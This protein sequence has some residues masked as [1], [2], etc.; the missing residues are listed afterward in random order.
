MNITN[1]MSAKWIVLLFTALVAGCGGGGGDEGG[2]G[3]N[4]ILGINDDTNNDTTSQPSVSVRDLKIDRDNTLS[5]VYEVDVDVDISAQS[6]ARAFISIC[7]NSDAKGDLKAI[8]YDNCMIK[9]RLDQGIGQYDLRIANHCTELIAVIWVMEKD[10]DPMTYT[11]THDKS[12]Q[13]Y[14]GIR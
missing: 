14:W 10:R 11:L 3:G 5:S 7:D 12:K 9:G 13:Q 2:S 8:D 1:T 6:T 4:E